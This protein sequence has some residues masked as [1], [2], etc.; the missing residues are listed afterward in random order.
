MKRSTEV[1]PQQQKLC[2]E[3]VCTCDENGSPCYPLKPY[4]G[5]R[6]VLTGSLGAMGSKDHVRAKLRTLGI[7]V[8][9]CITKDT[10]VV[11]LGNGGS[12]TK[13]TLAKF[14]GIKIL[15]EPGLL[16]FLRA[17]GL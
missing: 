14:Y 3:E 9:G 6:W 10:D 5:E 4:A 8:V 1:S 7:S 12:E 11:V 15:S 17:N 16:N 2:W 13:K